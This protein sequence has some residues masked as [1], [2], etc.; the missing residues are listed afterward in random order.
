M[1][2]LGKPTAKGY[3]RRRAPPTLSSGSEVIPSALP[4]TRGYRSTETQREVVARARLVVSYCSMA[5][6]EGAGGHTVTTLSIS[7]R[8]LSYWVRSEA[9]RSPWRTGNEFP[10]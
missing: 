6:G 2:Q 10:Q 1:A 9:A 8:S 3:E 4:A 7:C 5:A